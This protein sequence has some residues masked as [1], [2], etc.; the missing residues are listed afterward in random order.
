VAAAQHR[1]DAAREALDA[2]LRRKIATDEAAK[3]AYN[4]P[5]ID[6]ATPKAAL[7]AAVKALADAEAVNRRVDAYEKSQ[8]LYA[9]A[10]EAAKA[11][12]EAQAAVDAAREARAR[13]VAAARMPVENLGVDCGKLTLGGI[14]LRQASTS[15]Q[16]RVAV[17]LGLAANPKLRVVLIRDGSLL[18]DD[19]MLALREVDAQIWV[20]RVGGEGATVVIEDGEVL[21]GACPT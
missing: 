1:L 8:R 2:A 15:E 14:P 21:H 3:E 12:K 11:A 16:L 10:A 4:R 6:E 5:A 17:A 18:D 9:D 20:E 19:A 7:D 13:E